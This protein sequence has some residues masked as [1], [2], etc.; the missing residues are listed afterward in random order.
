MDSPVL[1]LRFIPLD[2]IAPHEEADDRR[3]SLLAEELARDGV[4]RNPPL[5][6]PA[7]ERF[8][9]LDGATRTEALR[10]LGSPHVVVQNVESLDEASVETWHHVVTG[11]DPD[12]L[13]DAM[14][15]VEG[16]RVEK[17]DGDAETRAVEYGGLCSIFLPDGRSFVAYPD[18]GAN[19]FAALSSFARRYGE[20]GRISRTLETGM[21]T[22]RTTYPRMAAFVEFPRFT[23]EQVLVAATS[24]TLLPAGITRFIVPGRVLRLD[25]SLELLLADSPLAEKNAWLHSHLAEKERLGRIRFYREPVYLLDE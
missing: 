11:P 4:V 16:I 2:A 8:V 20:V 25:V 15:A 13:L 24:G 6:T 12:E 9:L 22:L 3:A 17:V 5:V 1:P 18:P 23:T 14:G 7:G 10:R 21:E 19:R